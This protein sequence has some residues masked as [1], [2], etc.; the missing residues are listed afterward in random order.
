MRHSAS[1]CLSFDMF[2]GS[3]HQNWTNITYIVFVCIQVKH[4]NGATEAS[5]PSKLIS[6]ALKYREITMV[7]H[8]NKQRLG[9]LYRL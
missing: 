9:Q 3:T 8:C 1:M 7:Y 6:K 5:W 2:S 4:K